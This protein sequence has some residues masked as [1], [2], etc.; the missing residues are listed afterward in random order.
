M[1]QTGL[2][3]PRGQHRAP[4]QWPHGSWRKPT[5]WD[6]WSTE[7]WPSTVP[8][9][10]T[11][12]E[13]VPNPAALGEQAGP[14]PRQDLAPVP[15]PHP[16]PPQSSPRP[17]TSHTGVVTPSSA[18]GS[19]PCPHVP[20]RGPVSSQ[21][22]PVPVV[23]WPR[24]TPSSPAGDCPQPTGFWHQGGF[25][26]VPA[27][28]GPWELL[29]GDSSSSPFPSQP[30]NRWILA[31][32][33]Q[34][35]PL[36]PP[37]TRPGPHIAVTSP[38]PPVPSP[39]S[40]HR[41]CCSAADSRHSPGAS[42]GHGD[43]RRGGTRGHWCHAGT[44]GHGHWGETQTRL[45]GTGRMGL[46][47]GSIPT[48]TVPPLLSRLPLLPRPVTSAQRGGHRARHG[49]STPC[50]PPRHLR[51]QIPLFREPDPT[52]SPEPSSPEAG[53]VHGCR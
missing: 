36:H 27:L 13:G 5:G 6:A 46:S 44:W 37:C 24:V 43:T 10:G 39:S 17:R 12:P 25:G 1:F 50:P 47:A 7:G 14:A 48:T 21:A 11:S 18:P 16:D 31:A 52:G 45:G 32:P 20:Q 53:K 28:A 26:A 22:I 40:G 8:A 41:G 49:P 35:H 9:L 23:P 34:K 2:A 33:G 51:W 4:Q 3:Q 38:L 29:S 30:M 42:R 19:R 15:R